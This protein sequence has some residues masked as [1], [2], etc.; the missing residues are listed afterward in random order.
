MS[1]VNGVVCASDAR[2]ARCCGEL[3][4][5]RC[6][7]DLEDAKRQYPNH[8]WIAGLFEDRDAIRRT[9]EHWSD[10]TEEAAALSQQMHVSFRSALAFL[11]ENA[12]PSEIEEYKQF[13]LACGTKVAAAAGVPGPL[14][15]PDHPYPVSR[16]ESFQICLV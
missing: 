4:L 14:G 1:A 13:V 15:P 11:D 16:H 10:V 8:R 7:R 9:V 2:R 3:E 12:L 5:A 6:E